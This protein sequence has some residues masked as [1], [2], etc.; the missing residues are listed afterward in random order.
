[1]T[2]LFAGFLLIL[3][4]ISWLVV[5]AMDYEDEKKASHAIS[6]SG[7]FGNKR[8]VALCSYYRGKCIPQPVNLRSSHE[9]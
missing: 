2:D 8:P 9:D 1:M 4:A 5:G 3:L 6:H 7:S